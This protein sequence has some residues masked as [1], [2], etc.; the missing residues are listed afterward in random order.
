MLNG[1]HTRAMTT[2]RRLFLPVGIAPIAGISAA[3]T[4]LWWP[5]S[6][7]PTQEMVGTVLPNARALPAVDLS[8]HDGEPWQ[9]AHPDAQWQFV[10]F[11]FTHCPDV[12]P[13]TLADLAGMQQRLNQAGSQSTP[14]VVFISVDPGRDTLSRLERY[15]GHFHDDFVGVT[16]E[17]EAIDTLTR[18]LGI[19]YTLHEPNADGDY[20]VDHS[21]AI[22]LIDPSGQLRALWQPPHGRAVL[23]EEF[24]QIKKRFKGARG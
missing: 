1:W 24:M 4:M 11:G 9:A 12:C 13:T 8:R 21:A 17:R 3:G 22:L 14:E 10:F 5:E 18:A 6:S 16:G 23:A 19:S 2:L 7:P 15:V 20:A